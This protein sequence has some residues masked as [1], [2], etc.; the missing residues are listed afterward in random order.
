MKLHIR[1]TAKCGLSE[2]YDKVAREIGYISV[3]NLIYDCRH[4]N[5]SKEIQDEFSA[6]Y[7]EQAKEIDPYI[8]DTDIRTST[9]ILLAMG[10]PKVDV[11]LKVDE[12]EVFAGFITKRE[13][14]EK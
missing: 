6:Y 9:A 4:I 12:V 14:E 10:G 3:D 1:E 11:S 2:F 8:S 13:V 5:V 7:K